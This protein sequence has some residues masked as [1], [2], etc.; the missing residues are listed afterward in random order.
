[1]KK[2]LERKRT[3]NAGPWG[4][5]SGTSACK[6]GRDKRQYLLTGKKKKKKTISRNNN[7]VEWRKG[8]RG[9]ENKGDQ[10]N[11]LPSTTIIRK[12]KQLKFETNARW[13]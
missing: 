2:N 11:I 12:R 4:R 5:A 8:E 10:T 3:D 9:G 13:K 1:M 7:N 6:G